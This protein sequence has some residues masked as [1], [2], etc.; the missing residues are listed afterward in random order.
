MLGFL[1]IMGLFGATMP[2]SLLESSE[3]VSESELLSSELLVLSLLSVPL[4]SLSS[5]GDGGLCRSRIGC[6]AAPA[7]VDFIASRW[8]SISSMVGEW[9][10]AGD[11]G[12]LRLSFLPIC[13]ITVGLLGDNATAL[14]RAA[15]NL[16]G[17]LLE[18]CCTVTLAVALLVAVRPCDFLLLP[19]LEMG[20]ALV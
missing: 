12:G 5:V 3:L 8:S 11:E 14:L 20:E 19:I 9:V 16:F 15:M 6:N 10:P 13:R 18:G 17:D 7:S 1:A 4:S 2:S